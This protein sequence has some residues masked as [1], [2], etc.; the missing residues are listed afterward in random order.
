MFCSPRTHWLASPRATWRC[1]ELREP[2]VLCHLWKL[3]SRT[4]IESSSINMSFRALL[5]FAHLLSRLES[6]GVAWRSCKDQDYFPLESLLLLAR[7]SKVTWS[8]LPRVLARSTNCRKCS[9]ALH[10][11]ID[12]RQF[13]I[14]CIFWQL[15]KLCSHQVVKVRQVMY[16]VKAFPAKNWPPLATST[17]S[18]LVGKIVMAMVLMTKRRKRMPS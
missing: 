5:L 9:S 17:F 12:W 10:R 14:F 4:L 16:Q 15:K 2:W 3:V 8:S 11:H 1:L 18:S 7:C 6:F 13:G